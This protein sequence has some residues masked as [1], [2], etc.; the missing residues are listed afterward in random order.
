MPKT[1]R[2]NATLYSI[3]KIPNK[4]ELQQKASDH[5]SNIDF[6]PT[7]QGDVVATS[8]RRLSIRPNDVSNETPN[9]VSVVRRQDISLVRLHDVIE[10]RRDDV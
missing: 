8:Q 5:S 2:L 3:M 6:K 10:E 1:I 7:R 9:D 4:R